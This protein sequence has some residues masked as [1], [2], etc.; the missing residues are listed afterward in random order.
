[1]AEN[2]PLGP[3]SIDEKKFIEIHCLQDNWTDRR[4]AEELGRDILTV[5]KYRKKVGIH[6]GSKGSLKTEIK[7][8]VKTSINKQN[9][10]DAQKIQ[11]HKNTFKRTNRYK[12]LQK[13]LSETDLEVFVER[14]GSY[15]LQFEDMSESEQDILEILI[16]LKLRMEDN[17]KDYKNAQEYEAELK[18]KLA[19]RMD[20]DL[21]LENE[22]DRFIYEM[23]MSNNRAKQELNKDYR[24]TTNK[25]ENYAKMMNATREQRESQQR[26]GADTFLSLVRM[27]NDTQRRQEV[28]IY[29][30]RMK[31][32][33]ANKKNQMKKAYKFADGSI[34]PLLMDGSDYV[35]NPENPKNLADVEDVKLIE[36]TEK[37]VEE[38]KEEENE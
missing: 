1:M 20:K 23:M 7:D 32:A 34:E 9:L 15:S 13:Q 19:G 25:Y 28:G 3:L 18:T 5:S 21:D 11:A 24:E 8:I 10:D 14:W 2:K 12:A 26:V 37:E 4:I 36:D 17:R 16:S 35:D 30:E 29:N 38:G 27:M 6:K 22:A 31:L 33:T